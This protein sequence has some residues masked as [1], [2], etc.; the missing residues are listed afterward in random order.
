MNLT[1]ALILTAFTF[2]FNL[3]PLAG[4]C[5]DLAR[6][7]LFWIAHNED[8]A[9]LHENGGYS[10]EQISRFI[11]AGIDPQDLKPGVYIV[12]HLIDLTRIPSQYFQRQ[13]FS[14]NPAG[15][16]FQ[17][18]LQTEMLTARNAQQIQFLESFD[19]ALTTN[20]PTQINKMYR[21]AQMWTR[22]TINSSGPRIEYY[23]IP[24]E[25]NIFHPHE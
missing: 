22:T 4:A 14:G 24:L 25:V 5:S 9:H 2:A 13:D 15:M 16:G 23:A 8:L 11:Q 6:S 3:T 18:Y 17:E 12:F 1:L 19:F 21:S 20:D 7:Q 10:Q